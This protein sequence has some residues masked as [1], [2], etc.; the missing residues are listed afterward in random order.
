MDNIR[1]LGRDGGGAGGWRGLGGARHRVQDI[2]DVIVVEVVVLVMVVI[3]IIVIV[4]VVVVV[5]EDVKYNSNDW[6]SSIRAVQQIIY[7]QIISIKI[8]TNHYNCYNY[9][10]YYYYYN[11]TT[12]TTT[13]T[14]T[15]H[16]TYNNS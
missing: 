16:Y 8:I 11:T 15:L 14:T 2:H 3:I 7:L 10:H 9:H 13:T 5:V 1:V 12:T 4:V 6:S